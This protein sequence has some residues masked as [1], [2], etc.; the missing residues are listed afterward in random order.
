[1]AATISLM[2]LERSFVNARRVID[3]EHARVSRRTADR[4]VETM[5]ARAPVRTDEPTK[6]R[7]TPRGAV[8]DSIRVT[9]P[10]ESRPGPR[11]LDLFVGPRPP[12]QH[13]ARWLEYGTVKMTPRPFIGGAADPH[14]PRHQVDLARAAVRCFVEST[15]R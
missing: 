3:T 9:G 1:M 4:I 2:E 14:M 5:K 7:K 13:I 10:N 15:A 11:T 6:W 12:Y 8:R